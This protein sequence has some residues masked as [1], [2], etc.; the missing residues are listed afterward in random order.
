[1][2]STIKLYLMGAAA[3][4][5]LSFLTWGALHERA[6]EHKKDVAVAVKEVAKVEKQDVAITAAANTEIQHDTLIYK[7]IVSAPV[8][9]DIG[10]VCESPGGHAVPGSPGGDSSG[11]PATDSGAGNLYDPSGGLLTVGRKYDA[12]VRDLQAEIATLRKELA[13]AQK[14]HR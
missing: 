8:V 4:A 13:D 3:A 11:H 5:I 1:M 10:L 14:A 12:W 9:G 7:Q 6:V 2:F